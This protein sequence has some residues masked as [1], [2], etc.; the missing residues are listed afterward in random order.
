M[1]A[2]TLPVVP[3]ELSS[4]PESEQTPAF[5]RLRDPGPNPHGS[6]P[7]KG[8]QG[9]SEGILHG[10]VQGSLWMS[11]KKGTASRRVIIKLL[12]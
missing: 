4:S 9:E 2:R 3:P 8:L 1:A 11:I 5:F 10:E 12:Y 6:A 7:R